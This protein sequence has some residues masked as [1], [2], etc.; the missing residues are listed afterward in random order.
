MINKTKRF[1]DKIQQFDKKVNGVGC[2]QSPGK[3]FNLQRQGF[4]MH[5]TF[6]SV[7]GVIH[8]KS[9]LDG[10]TGYLN[11]LFPVLRDNF[12]DFEIILVNNVPEWR[13]TDLIAPLPAALKQQVFLLQLSSR[14]NKNHAIL[15]G[16]DRANGDYTIILETCFAGQPEVVLDL[17]HKSQEQYDVVYLRAHERETQRGWKW[18][19]AIFYF[20]LQRFS[21]LQI[22]E[23]AH[24]TRIISRRA[25]NS[26]LRLREN[27][28]YMKAI[29]AIVG[30][31][32]TFLDTNQPLPA[33][34]DMGER[35]RTSLVAITSYT[36]FLRSALLWIF[37]LSFLFLIGVIANA[38][39]VKFTQTD[40]LGNAA[41][42]DSGWTFLVVL[43][44]IFFA[45]TTLNLYIISIYLS[46]IYTEIKQRPPY[47]IESVERF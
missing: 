31:R 38:L 29:Y 47:I 27:L 15:A 7:I 1:D 44:A 42:A 21:T 10:L 26:L 19:Y 13:L 16:L 40:L 41:I 3:G 25:L 32:T 9:D 5:N 17:Y 43:I 12:S 30:Y 14:T 22:D 4:T 35:F 28:R 2:L 34:E 20:I 46:N 37:L 11:G 45:V 6:V 18:L 36:T 23:K 24:N 8:Q 33:D 39:K